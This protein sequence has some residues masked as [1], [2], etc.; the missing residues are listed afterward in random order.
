VC[1]DHRRWFKDRQFHPTPPS[2]GQATKPGPRVLW[3][4]QSGKPQLS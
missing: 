1:G 4:S 2:L 3:G